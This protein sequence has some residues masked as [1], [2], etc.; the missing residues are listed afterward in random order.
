MTAVT[1]LSAGR[2]RGLSVI[3][4]IC[5][6]AMLAGDIV[7]VAQAPPTARAAFIANLRIHGTAATAVGA[8]TIAVD[9][10]DFDMLT[11]KVVFGDADHRTTGRARARCERR[12]RAEK[13]CKTRAP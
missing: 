6:A 9:L 4:G 12:G 8:V 5:L 13:Q 3:V 1:P 2:K 11:A 7:P 10:V